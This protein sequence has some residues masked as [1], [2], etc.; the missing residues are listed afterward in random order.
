MN[1]KHLFSPSHGFLC[2]LLSRSLFVS[3][4]KF[5]CQP[6]STKGSYISAVLPLVERRQ[7]VYFLLSHSSSTAAADLQNTENIMWEYVYMNLKYKPVFFLRYIYITYLVSLICLKIKIHFKINLPKIITSQKIYLL[8][9]I[10]TTNIHSCIV[11]K[12][13]INCT[14]LQ[15][16][17][18]KLHIFKRRKH[19]LEWYRLMM[20]FSL[21]YAVLGFNLWFLISHMKYR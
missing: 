15:Y 2:L 18:F 7:M 10:F 8:D 6:L 11:L 12:S 17:K 14:F 4:C 9:F 1:P 19:I 16:Y 5:T 3:Y 21:T 20:D 13:I